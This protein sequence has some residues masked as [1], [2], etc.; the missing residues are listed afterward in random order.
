MLIDILSISFLKMSD[1]SI[2]I[3]QKVFDESLNFMADAIHKY[4]IDNNIFYLGEE[5]P[6]D[7]EA[8]LSNILA[9]RIQS[10]EYDP[11]NDGDEMSGPRN[12]YRGIGPKARIFIEMGQSS[13]TTFVCNTLFSL[14]EISR[15]AEPEKDKEY[16]I[17]NAVKLLFWI[18][19][20]FASIGFQTYCPDATE[21]E[22]S[23]YSQRSEHFVTVDLK[24]NQEM[25][26][27]YLREH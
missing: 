10:G 21:E 23:W 7:V 17:N 18:H 25:Y 26:K 22:K 12:N 6:R 27:T 1:S 11:E 14:L 4:I 19:L 16:H 2:D 15:N 3:Q 5:N 20:S 13:Y 24:R 9:E 8:R